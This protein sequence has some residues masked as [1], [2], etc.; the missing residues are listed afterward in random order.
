MLPLPKKSEYEIFTLFLNMITSHY[1]IMYVLVRVHRTKI[2]HSVPRTTLLVAQFLVKHKR[3][4]F[5]KK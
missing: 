1:I 5:G 4:A 2:R 3:L